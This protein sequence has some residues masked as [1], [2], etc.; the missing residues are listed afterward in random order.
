MKKLLSLLSFLC[1]YLLGYGQNVDV[2]Y[3]H[4]KQRCVTCLSIEKYAKEA[5]QEIGADK[6][7]KGH[8][9]FEAIDFSTEEGNS[10]AQEYKVAWS[11]LFII[12]GDV[13]KDI[14][15][16]AFR[17][18]KSQPEEFK[19]LLKLEIESIQQ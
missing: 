19:R 10:I 12:N 8:V 1:L 14:T 16:L 5:V 4:G 9:R 7:T 3:F 6:Q 11:T 18:A 13:R 2:V 15:Q 17:Y